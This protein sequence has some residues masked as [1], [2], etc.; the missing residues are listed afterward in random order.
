MKGLT[1]FQYFSVAMIIPPDVT[2]KIFPGQCY[3]RVETC[4]IVSNIKIVHAPRTGIELTYNIL[5]TKTKNNIY[6][7]QRRVEGVK[8]WKYYAR[9][10]Y[11]NIDFS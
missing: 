11:Q 5:K 1:I 6:A 10:Y 3:S 8:I 4:K 9:P 7:T 2:L